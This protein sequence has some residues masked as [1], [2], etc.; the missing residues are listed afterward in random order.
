MRCLVQPLTQGMLESGT[1]HVNDFSNDRYRDLFGQDGSDIEADRHVNAFQA[2][3]RDS[4]ALELIGNG[5]NLSF[6][7]DHSDVAGVRLHRPP[8]H[9]LIFLVTPRNDNHVCIV[10]GHDLVKSLLEAGLPPKQILV[11]DRRLSDL[12]LAGYFDLAER[13]G[14]RV[15]GSAEAGYDEKT[16]Y[17]T[18]LLG[19]LVWGDLEFGRKGEGVGRKS[20]VSRLVTGQ[21]TKII[22]ITPLLNH[23]LVGVSGNLWGLA[24]GSVDNTLRFETDADRLATAVPEIVALPQLGDRVVLNIVDAL[25]CQYQ[26]EE[27]GMLH[28]STPLN[29]LWFS[30]DPVALDV[31]AIQELDSQRRAARVLAPKTSLELY[32]NASLLE[33]G[34]SDPRRIDVRRLPE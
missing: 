11:W 21:M 24:L 20:F 5:A 8:Q 27:R 28:Y 18:A 16:F 10:V 7:S 13:F 6:A 34:I 30:T 9:V 4:L 33:I 25:I 17:E 1:P 15:A 31:L 19:Q 12:R 26:G 23:N 32:Q 3:S 2:F 29:Q 22:N 14:V